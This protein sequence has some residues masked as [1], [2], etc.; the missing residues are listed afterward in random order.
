MS[1]PI[2]QVDAFANLAFTG[3]PAAVCL[4]E[5][6]P[7]ASWMQRVAGEMNLS[8]TAFL[9]P[10]GD[11]Y[12]LRWFTPT[13]EV[14]L[15]GHATLASA[16]ALYERERVGE[17]ETVTF[18]TKGGELACERDE[19]GWIT[20]SFPAHPP[21]EGAKDAD[22][23]AEA[24][25]VDPAWVGDSDLDRFAVLDDERTVRELEPD[26][27]RVA[28]L[29][30]RGLIVTA[31]S[32]DESAVDFVSR[33]FAPSAGVDEDPVTG[34]AHCVLGPYWADRLGEDEVVGRQV[35]AR[36]GTVR[37]SVG[38]DQ[39]DLSGQAVTVF[40]GELAGSAEP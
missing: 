4:L 35:S 31:A 17:D 30:G 28:Q 5:E 40:E 29:G 1:V 39:V 19:E 22:L 2:L 10:E 6:E 27:D 13:T 34:S 36:G 24:L 8:E 11:G 38:E 7:S 3:N 18:D 26:L 20:M 23:I 9:W 16:H 12:A 32:E 25:G 15:C 37:V 33:F 21:S 14:E